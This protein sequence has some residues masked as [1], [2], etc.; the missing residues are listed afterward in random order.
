MSGIAS[1]EG[2][3]T[4]ALFWGGT[5]V[6][7]VVLS[8]VANAWNTCPWHHPCTPLHGW[9]MAL[10][11][12]CFDCMDLMNILAQITYPLRKSYGCQTYCYR[13][14][15]A[16]GHEESH[17]SFDDLNF[18]VLWLCYRLRTMSWHVLRIPY[19]PIEHWAWSGE[20]FR[21][22]QIGFAQVRGIPR[23]FTKQYCRS[24]ALQVL[25]Q[26]SEN[27][28]MMGRRDAYRL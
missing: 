23:D 3:G 10:A 5:H 4:I 13:M 11:L 2:E 24:W 25:T 26:H 9:C 16:W 15:N 20:S 22:T 18:N 21:E 6:K 28:K 8:S 27:K 14:L 17:H 7:R 19:F 12:L 1:V